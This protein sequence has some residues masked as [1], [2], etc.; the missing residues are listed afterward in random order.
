MAYKLVLEVEVTSTGLATSHDHDSGTCS[1]SPNSSFALHDS[2]TDQAYRDKEVFGNAKSSFPPCS[3]R[4]DYVNFPP[5]LNINRPLTP[6]S[7]FQPLHSNRFPRETG[8]NLTCNG[9]SS[10]HLLASKDLEA[11]SSSVGNHEEVDMTISTLTTTC[12][13]PLETPILQV[14]NQGHTYQISPR[15]ES[16]NPKESR[17]AIQAPS[18]SIS[19]TPLP[20]ITAARSILRTDYL[21][22]L[23]AE[24]PRWAQG[25]LWDHEQVNN[26]QLMSADPEYYKLQIAYSEVCQLNRWM[27]DDVIRS[28]MA[29]IR[30]HLEYVR[31]CEIWRKCQGKG[32][33]GRGDTTC[34]IDHILEK[35]HHDWP[36]LSKTQ[37]STLRARF[38]ERK[39]YGKRWA[40]LSDELGKSVLFLCSQKVA[41]MVCNT[42]VTFKMLSTLVDQ[43]VYMEENA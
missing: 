40:V 7:E 15:N 9:T 18:A 30:L 23:E 6:L 37:C 4:I 33:I 24:L 11:L 39:R 10:S 20:V 31:I 32:R 36:K 29:L 16:T 25:G 3:E 28:R 35:A 12:Q 2:A 13:W 41:A 34:I 1:F 22:Y 21:E 26:S 43:I 5:D 19:N 42:T 38:H 14:Q 17:I 8:D 27:E